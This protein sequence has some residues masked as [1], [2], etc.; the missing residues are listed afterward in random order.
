METISVGVVVAIVVFVSLCCFVGGCF[1]RSFFLTTARHDMQRVVVGRRELDA[2][3]DD[4]FDAEYSEGFDA[5]TIA[6]TTRQLTDDRRN[7]DHEI[8]HRRIASNIDVMTSNPDVLQA[9]RA[10]MRRQIPRKNPSPNLYLRGENEEDAV[11][12]VVNNNIEVAAEPIT[13]SQTS[14]LSSIIREHL[15]ANDSSSSVFTGNVKKS[16]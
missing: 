16:R 11:D 1:M 6:E 15:R 7:V 5:D 13:T 12:D 14:H 8:T 10:A 4:E 3:T 2:I 9:I